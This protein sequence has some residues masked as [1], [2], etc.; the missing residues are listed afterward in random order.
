MIFLE[1]FLSVEIFLEWKWALQ[2]T[3]VT[4]GTLLLHVTG[5]RFFTSTA[6]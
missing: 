4:G 3:G 6:N 1:N 2:E 5:V